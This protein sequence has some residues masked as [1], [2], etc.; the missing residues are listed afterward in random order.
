VS[1][2]E[3]LTDF[4]QEAKTAQ[5]AHAAFLLRYPRRSVVSNGAMSK[6]ALSS[7]LNSVIAAYATPPT[8]FNRGFKG[9]KHRKTAPPTHAQIIYRKSGLHI[10]TAKT[11]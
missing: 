2:A 7:D 5:D 9:Q 8:C 4:L 3:S 10:Q 6:V 1:R 11:R